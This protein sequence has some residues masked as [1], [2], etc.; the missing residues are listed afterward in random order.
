MVDDAVAQVERLLALAVPAK[1]IGIEGDCLGASIATLAVAKL[2]E[3][4]YPV[5]LYNL[6]SFRSLPRFLEGYLLPETSTKADFLNPLTY[7][8]YIAVGFIR[9]VLMPLIW[10]ARW[11]LNVATAWNSIPSADKDYGVI[12]NSADAQGP[13]EVDGCIHNT[14][15]SVASIVDEQR[16]TLQA[17]ETNKER[18]TQEQ[19]AVLDDSP[20]RH[21]F[22]PDPKPQSFD[23]EAAKE[24]AQTYG[25]LPHFLGRRSLLIREGEEGATAH[26]HMVDFFK[27]SFR[28]EAVM[29]IMNGLDPSNP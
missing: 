13:N 25:S 3:R 20:A 29:P 28:R 7:L 10:V 22:K 19:I 2:Q 17:K 9:C 6:R 12:R 23:S 4:H 24:K 5:K 1:N 26:N 14:W 15:A 27:T 11:D 18:L 21:C 8:K 16:K